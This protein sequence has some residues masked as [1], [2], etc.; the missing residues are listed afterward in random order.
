MKNLAD[1]FPRLAKKD[2]SKLHFCAEK[3][4]AKLSGLMQESLETGRTVGEHTCLSIEGYGFPERV[5]ASIAQDLAF[6]DPTH[7]L[8]ELIFYFMRDDIID[9]PFPQNGNRYAERLTIAMQTFLDEY[10]K[11]D[12]MLEVNYRNFS[13]FYAE[14]SVLDYSDSEIL[15]LRQAAWVVANHCQIEGV[16]IS[17]FDASLFFNFLDDDI[18]TVAECLNTAYPSDGDVS[19]NGEVFREDVG[20]TEKQ[21]R[22]FFMTAKPVIEEVLR[23]FSEARNDET[24]D[25]IISM[26]FMKSDAKARI[27]VSLL[28]N[29]P[30]PDLAQ[31][32]YDRGFGHHLK[33]AQRSESFQA[34]A[35]AAE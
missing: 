22:L 34:N 27:L 11:T 6:H 13:N 3:Q 18:Q 31:I 30:L 1:L 8:V 25:S 7:T 23:R 17:A 32:L 12:A 33:A 10:T 21:K 16:D 28:N 26:P 35:P 19:Q 5:T 2:P 29:I 4:R 15:K 9:I 24:F 14:V 20:P